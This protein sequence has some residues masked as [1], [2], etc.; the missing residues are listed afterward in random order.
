[1]NTIALF[2]HLNVFGLDKK[3]TLLMMITQPI[4]HNNNQIR[5]AH[6]DKLNVQM[7]IPRFPALHSK[8]RLVIFKMANV[9]KFMI[10]HPFKVFIIVEFQD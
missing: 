2:F 3:Q 6:A 8:V 9:C 7:L 4:I 10:V 1:M 5:M